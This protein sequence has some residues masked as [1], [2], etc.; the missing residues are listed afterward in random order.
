M[1][2]RIIGDIALVSSKTPLIPLRDYIYECNKGKQANFVYFT[3]TMDA[4]VWGAEL[5]QGSGKGRIYIVEPT[6]AFEDDPNLTDKKYP[7]NPTLSFRTKEPLRIVGVIEQW[8]EHPQDV[9]QNMIGS[10]AKAKAEG[11]EAINE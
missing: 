11:V 9:L 6:G 10:L 3:A 5:A 7:G 4:A 2:T 1:Q 8:K